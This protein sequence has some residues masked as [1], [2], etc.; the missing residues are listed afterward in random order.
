MGLHCQGLN[1]SLPAHAS[2]APLSLTMQ[3]ILEFLFLE[4]HTSELKREGRERGASATIALGQCRLCF[5]D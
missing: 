3:V 2:L 5:F 1:I 4:E